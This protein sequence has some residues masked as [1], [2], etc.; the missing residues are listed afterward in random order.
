M[1]RDVLHQ[2]IFISLIA[3]FEGWGT[4]VCSAKVVV[5][6]SPFCTVFFKGL[7]VLCQASCFEGEWVFSIS[8]F[9]ERCSRSR[10]ES[11][12][13]LETWLEVHPVL[14]GIAEF[15]LKKSILDQTLN[16]I[17]IHLL[18]HKFICYRLPQRQERIYCVLYRIKQ[19][20]ID[21]FQMFWYALHTRI[22]QVSVGCS[23]VHFIVFL[24]VTVLMPV[25]VESLWVEAV[26]VHFPYQSLLLI[27]NFKH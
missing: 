6:G 22:R 14:C 5:T 9:V 17:L 3:L 12:I 15:Y 23:V 10:F 7:L 20:V 8:H 24:G 1:T 21:E 11:L 25:A 26:F 16:T 27:L 18:S 13:S 4:Q 19:S 2:K